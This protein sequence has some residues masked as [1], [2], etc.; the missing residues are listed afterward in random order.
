MRDVARADARMILRARHVQSVCDANRGDSNLGMTAIF[1]SLLVLACLANCLSV[2]QSTG[3]QENAIDRGRRTT[4]ALYDLIRSIAFPESPAL[5]VNQHNL[6]NRFLLLMP[7]KVLNYFDYY[8]GREY[9][10]FIQ[11][12][13]LIII[14]IL[15]ISLFVILYNRNTKR[16]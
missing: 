13:G 1:V 3:D 14:I 7:G 11:V 9:T 12:V 16:A 2:T 15:Y 4:A 6:D 5:D 10:K 8:P